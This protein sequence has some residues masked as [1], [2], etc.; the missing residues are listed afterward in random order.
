MPWS[1]TWFFYFEDHDFDWPNDRYCFFV[2]D[3]DR[4]ILPR[5][6]LSGIPARDI[7]FR[8]D[9]LMSLEEQPHSSTSDIDRP[10]ALSR[11]WY[12]R[13]YTETIEGQ[14]MVASERRLF[15]FAR[16]PQ[17][18]VDMGEMGKGG[19]GQAHDAELLGRLDRIV[20]V[21]ERFDRFVNRLP[22][23]IFKVAVL[24]LA[25]LLLVRLIRWLI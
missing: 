23:L 18:E 12:P 6:V 25:A 4:I 19:I 20:N 13:F 17:A 10:T 14:L 9:V 2:V 5:A 15:Y 7:E 16:P 21:L 11:V 8:P 22:W 1:L 3:H 24:I